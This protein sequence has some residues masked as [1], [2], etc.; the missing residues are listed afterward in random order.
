[1]SHIFVRLT[2]SLVIPIGLVAQQRL[3]PDQFRSLGKTCIPQSD[4]RL[5]T[6]IVKTE[7][8][9]NPNAISL[10]YPATLA[11]K[12]GLP[13][14]KVYLKQQPRDVVMAREW[15][16]K[17]LIQ[18]IT[19]SVGLMQIN[20]QAGYPVD[21]LLTPCKNLQI[22]WL[23]FSKDYRIAVQHVHDPH[24]ALPIALNLYNSGIPYTNSDYSRAVLS[25]IR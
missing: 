16:N 24:R 11:K 8:N 10:N 5:V 12:F 21:D 17:L 25:Q 9:F 23:M 18:G 6:A 13:T 3:S 2:L 22:G 4:R 1:M 7:S 19:V 15:I 14:G 20:V